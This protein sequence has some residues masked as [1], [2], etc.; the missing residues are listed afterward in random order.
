MMRTSPIP[1]IN[2]WYPRMTDAM[3]IATGAVVLGVILLLLSADRFV[4]GAAAIARQ[5]GMPPLLIGMIVIGFGSSMPE[6]L[7]ATLSSWEG[8]PELALGHAFG[9][10]ITNIALILG[11]PALISPIAVQSSLIGREL[12]LLTAITAISA[13]LLVPDG[14]LSRSDGF[15]LIVMFLVIMG[16]TIQMNRKTEE[17]ELANSVDS[18]DKGKL[19]TARAWIYLLG[20]LGILILSSRMLVW[21]GTSIAVT[22][23]ISQL[24]IGLTIVAIGTSLPELAS[25]IAAVRKGQHALAIGNVIGSNMFNTSVVIGLSGTIAPSLIMMDLI[26]RDF[27]LLLFLT[28]ALFIMCYPWRGPGTGGINRREGGLLLATYL[29][30]NTILFL[31]ATT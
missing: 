29:A 22:L 23:G 20:G 16:W 17:D 3:V 26:R 11:L 24:I 28:L 12:P 21:G 6:M 25:S 7:I 19:T 30:Y 18:S 15:I 5:L 27:P 1:G 14:F 9:S 8:S 13:L 2:L 31:Q 4:D 10:N